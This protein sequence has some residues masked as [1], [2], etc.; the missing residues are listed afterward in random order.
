MW[1]RAAMTRWR[2]WMLQALLAGSVCA[3]EE[4]LPQD[5]E[6]ALEIDPPVLIESRG[7]DG[8]LVLKGAGPVTDSDQELAK[9]E[10]DL[11]RA[12]RSAEGADRMFRSGII[13]KAEAEARVLKVVQ[14]EAKLADA[15]LATAKRKAGEESVAEADEAAVA[16]A[17]EAARRATEERKRAEL[18][19]ALRNLQRQQKLLALGS[20]RKADVNRAEQ[21]LAELQRAAQD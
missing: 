18:E 6:E 3:G 5:P 20:G 7:A 19:A 4:A 11:A 15:R 1:Y 17:A 14:L 16:Q 12:K 13:A 9:L 2:G 8:T 21:K 10:K